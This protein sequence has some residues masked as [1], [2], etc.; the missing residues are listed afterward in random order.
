MIM[1]TRPTVCT[2]HIADLCEST[3]KDEDAILDHMGFPGQG[4]W[5]LTLST[6]T[7]WY[8]IAS[9]KLEKEKNGPL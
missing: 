5:V 4:I 7:T 9:F 8:M 1:S 2:R 6:H 3:G